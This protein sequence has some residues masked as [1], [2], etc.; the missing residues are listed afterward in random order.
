MKT[1]AWTS[2][3]FGQGHPRRETV[4]LEEPSDNEALVRIVATGICGT[5]VHASAGHFPTPEGVILGHEGGGVVE[6]VGKNGPSRFLTSVLTPSHA[7]QARR[8]RRVLI[9]LL[10]GVQALQVG[11]AELVREGA[12]TPRP[13]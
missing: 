1:E 7:R 2:R 6:A 11:Q 4:E 3:K 10:R 13:G 9:P 8:P 12:L 5:D